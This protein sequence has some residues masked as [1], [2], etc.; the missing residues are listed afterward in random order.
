MFSC[1]AMLGCSYIGFVAHTYYK[2]LLAMICDSLSPDLRCVPCS[3]PTLFPS[4]QCR[5]CVCW[6]HQAASTVH[7]LVRPEE[8]VLVVV[9]MRLY[10]CATPRITV[11]PC[12]SWCSQFCVKDMFSFASTVVFHHLATVWSVGAVIIIIWPVGLCNTRQPLTR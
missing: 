12:V 4:F 1:V 3:F 2:L 6:C 5:V 10:V 8:S 11:S 9:S 7:V